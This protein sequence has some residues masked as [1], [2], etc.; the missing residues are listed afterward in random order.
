M[1]L[2]KQTK[3]YNSKSRHRMSPDGYIHDLYTGR[4]VGLVPEDRREFM[5]TYGRN[6]DSY[7]KKYIDGKPSGIYFSPDA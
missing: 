1:Q 2:V 5:L 4:I 6:R 7:L 3:S